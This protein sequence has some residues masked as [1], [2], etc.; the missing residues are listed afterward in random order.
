MPDSKTQFAQN[1]KTFSGD[2]LMKIGLDVLSYAHNS[3]MVIE[4]IAQ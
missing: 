4:I 3:S 1:N 2:Y